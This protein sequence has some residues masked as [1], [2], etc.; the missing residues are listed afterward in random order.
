MRRVARWPAVVFL[1][2]CCEHGAAAQQPASVKVWPVKAPGETD[3]V[4]EEKL[5]P[6]KPKALAQ[7]LL[8]NVSEPTLTVYRPAKEKDTGVAVVVCPGGGYRVLAMDLEGEEVAAWLNSIGV[9]GIVLKYRVPARKDVAQHKL[10]LAD[11]QRALSVVRA[12]AKE[13]GIDPKRVGILGFSA[14]GHLAAAAATNYAKRAYDPIDETDTLLCR[15]DFVVLVYP[16]YLAAKG[17]GLNPEIRVTTRTPPTFL[18]HAGDDPISPENSVTFYQA[19][20]R[21]KV[22]AELH[23]YAGGGHGF[24]L[25]RSERPCSSWPQRCEEWMSARGI[26]DKHVGEVSP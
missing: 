10:P 26:L 15:P 21:N 4:G 22:P 9:T 6:A 24:G 13:W 7:K 20:R 3:E 12:R 11:A 25:R 1:L 17:G 8:T 5:L 2:C 23:I 19:L 14:G 18:V 16:A